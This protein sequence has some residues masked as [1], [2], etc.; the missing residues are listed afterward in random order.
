MRGGVRE[1]E[2]DYISIILLPP[3]SHASSSFSRKFNIANF[4][5]TRTPTHAYNMNYCFRALNIIVIFP[6]LILLIK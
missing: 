6:T 3:M 2:W 1:R 4:H 5:E